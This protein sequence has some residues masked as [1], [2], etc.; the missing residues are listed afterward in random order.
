M[1]ETVGDQMAAL[2][3]CAHARFTG[4]VGVCMATS[5]P[6]RDRRVHLVAAGVDGRRREGRFDQLARHPV[7]TAAAATTGRAVRG[8]R[9]PLMDAGGRLRA[10]EFGT[11]VG[12]RNH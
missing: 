5:G 1:S 8:R 10:G 9:V 11:G 2:M 3:A 4:E 6:R 7:R 12:E